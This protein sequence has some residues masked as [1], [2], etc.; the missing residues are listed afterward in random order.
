MFPLF[1]NDEKFG[2]T[3]YRAFLSILNHARLSD[4]RTAFVKETLIAYDGA[5]EYVCK[6]EL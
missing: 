4:H 2:T 1:Y 3:V 6:V 5:G